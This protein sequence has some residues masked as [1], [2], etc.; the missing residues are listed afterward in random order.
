MKREIKKQIFGIIGLLITL[1]LFRSSAIAV[2]FEAEGIIKRSSLSVNFSSDFHVYVNGEKYYIKYS[3]PG[4]INDIEFGYNGDY[5]RGLLK[6]SINVY[7]AV[8]RP[9]PVLQDWC[10][11]EAGTIWLGLCSAQYFRSLKTNIIYPILIDGIN[12]ANQPK[13]GFQCPAKIEYLSKSN[14]T[15]KSLEFYS[16]NLQY[17][18]RIKYEALAFTNIGGESIPIHFK[19]IQVCSNYDYSPPKGKTFYMTNEIHE[20]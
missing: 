4:P 12:I 5:I 10:N 20:V 6:S 9:G 18:S 11:C 17:V 3:K 16:D 8:V 1:L 14:R 13:C 19:L 7:D 2:E 15:L